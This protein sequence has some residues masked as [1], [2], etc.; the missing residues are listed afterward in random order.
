LKPLTKILVTALVVSGLA[1]AGIL[2][3]G[4][5]R[6]AEN[7][8]QEKQTAAVAKLDA[9][10]VR[11]VA[12]GLIE[13]RNG[14]I[15]VAGPSGSSGARIGQL[16]V[17]E[18]DSLVKGDV[19]AVLDSEPGL[20][21]LLLQ[22][23][24]TVDSR[25]LEFDRSALSSSKTILTLKASL[26]QNSADRDRAAA[27]LAKQQDLVK[28]GQYS[29]SSLRDKELALASTQQKVKSAEFELD[30]ANQQSQNGDS[31]DVASARVTLNSAKAALSKAEEDHALTIIKSPVDGVVLSVQTRA[32]EA[33]GDSGVVKIAETGN[34]E[35]RA[36][37]FEADV[38]K[39]RMRQRVSIDSRIIAPA[40]V[41]TVRWIS[42]SIE[43]QT[44]LSDDPTVNTDNRVVTVRISLDPVS[45]QRASRLINHQVRATFDISQAEPL[46]GAISSAN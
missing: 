36:E 40:L 7:K 24:A 18:G 39:I 11:V 9:A 4:L 26:D 23:K 25:Q 43:K 33:L 44:L 12:L 6:A 16:N 20:A 13:P 17:S 8:Q 10:P 19:I 29:R 45:M 30:Y 27:D 35:V 28:S 46:I 32:G 15:A 21:A 31:L 3:W 37:V 42:P 2:G 1:S 34:L 38:N 14:V 41:G 5:Y 22:A